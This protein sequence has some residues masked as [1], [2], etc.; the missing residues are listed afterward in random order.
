MKNFNVIFTVLLITATSLSLTG[1]LAAAVGGGFSA[2]NAKDAEARP[3]S[4]KA[5]VSMSK[6]SAFN[7]ALRALTVS[8]RSISSTNFDSGLVQGKIGDNIVTIILAAKS[9]SQTEME[10]TVSF[11][12]NFSLSSNQHL[13]NDLNT[14]WSYIDT[15]SK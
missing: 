6:T 11:V 9:D 8:G 13:D 2:V 5:V 10:I 15:T 3:A 4:K 7:A 12:G 1:C 14:L